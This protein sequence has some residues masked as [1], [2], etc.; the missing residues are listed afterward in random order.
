MIAVV[1]PLTSLAVGRRRAWRCGSSRPD[2]PA[3]A[4]RRRARRRQP[5]RRRPQPRARAAARRRPGAQARR[6]EAHRQPAP[7][8]HRRRLGR[9]AHGGRGARLAVGCMELRRRR[10]A[11]IVDFVLAFVIALFLWTG[12]TAAMASAPAPAPA[13]R[14]GRPRPGPPHAH[15]PATTCRS[16]RPYAGRRRPQAGSIVTVTSDGRP[17]GSSTRPRCSPRP[18]ERRPWVAVSHRRPHP[19]R[20]AERCPADIAGEDADPGDQSHPGHR[21]PPGRGRRLRSTACWPP[22]TSTGRSGP[23]AAAQSGCPALTA[24]PD[25]ARRHP[26]EALVRASTA[27]RC[28]RGS[29]CG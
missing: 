25:A 27:A 28:G 18:E 26:R 11:D 15:R 12:A 8:H 5:A 23:S 10:S 29:G 6:L 24:Q 9:P 14:P 19:R 4:R 16:P 2:G 22:P 17:S 7:R 20:R 3:A 1:G 13:S 21:V